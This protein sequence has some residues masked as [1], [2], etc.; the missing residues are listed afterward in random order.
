MEGSFDGVWVEGEIS[1]F[2]AAAS[3]H[4][5]FSLKDAGAQVKAVMWRGARTSLRFELADGVKVTAYG[6]LTVYEPRGEYQLVAERME[7]LGLG[8][9]QLAFE[10]LKRKLEAEG[11]FERG[12]KRLLPALPRR[13]AVITSPTGAV[14]QD[15]LNITARRC[16][17]LSLVVIPVRVQGAGAAQAIAQALRGVGQ[18]L[19]GTVDLVV[20]AR[21]GG[22]MED[23]WAFNEEPVARAIVGC[24]YPVISAVGHETDFTIADFCADLRAPTPSAAAELMA[25][26]RDELRQRIDQQQEGLVQAMQDRLER[27]RLQ[28]E[29]STRQ[30]QGLSPARVLE[31]HQ[32]WLQ[33]LRERM[34]KSVGHA[35]AVRG[36]ALEGLTEKLKA[37]SPLAILARGYAAAFSLPKGILVKQ[38]EDA[39]PGT[40]IRILLGQGVL[41]ADVL[42]HEEG[43]HGR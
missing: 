21:G 26:S 33:G 4:Y 34:R 7:P 11:L 30:L 2:K 18:G 14:I 28:W 13:V 17:Y 40:Q 42:H 8:A 19:A 24:P 29:R 10:Q 9:L 1:N 43:K 35:V 3:G 12:R 16:P 23:L 22:S 32:L 41:V 5:Y 15:I 27:L 20:L 39:P 31:Q 6:K 36:L 37:L 38:A 25:P